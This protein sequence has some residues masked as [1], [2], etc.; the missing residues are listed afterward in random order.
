VSD[1][2]TCPACGWPGLTEAPRSASGGGSYETCPSC[3]FE[4]GFTDDD[5]GFT[6]ASWR[7]KWI[8]DGMPWSTTYEP[9]PTSWDPEVQV[10]TVR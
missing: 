4:F 7:R 5:L 9:P 3:G 10:R 1:T 2:Y 8:D 6:Y